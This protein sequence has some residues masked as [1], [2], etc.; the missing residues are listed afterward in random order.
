MIVIKTR[1]VEI[2]GEDISGAM[3]FPFILVH[4]E[5]S[6]PSVIRHEV[7]HLKQCVECA[8]LPFYLIYLINYIVNLFRF[9]FNHL[10][11]YRRIAFEKEAYFGMFDDRYLIK[12]KLYNWVRYLK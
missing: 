3:L 11:A 4:P 10:K 8:I 9:G 12:R 7:I 2:L 5:K 6:S 1:I